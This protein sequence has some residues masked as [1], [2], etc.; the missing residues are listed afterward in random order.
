MIKMARLFIHLDYNPVNKDI[1][2]QSFD[3]KFYAMIVVE[4]TGVVK[5]K[6]EL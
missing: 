1:N 5:G 3:E 6:L 2:S 4:F